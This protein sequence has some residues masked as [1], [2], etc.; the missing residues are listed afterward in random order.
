MLEFATSTLMTVY[1]ARPTNRL[2]IFMVVLACH[3][4]QKL[5]TTIAIDQWFMDLL[6]NQVSAPVWFDK[7]FKN[8]T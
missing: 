7:R 1:S 5:P 6:P 3:C 2:D 4:G 8:Q